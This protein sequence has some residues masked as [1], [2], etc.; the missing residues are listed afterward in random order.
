MSDTALAPYRQALEQTYLP[1]A[2]VPARPLSLWDTYRA[3][4]V[5]PADPM[6]R[7]QSAVT[8]MRHSLE[9]AALG[10]LLGAIHGKM[11]L[12]I[13]GKYPIDGIL[14]AVLLAMSV[15]E[16]HKPDGFSSD[17]RALS[18]CCTSV[19]FFRKTS[20]WVSKP[21]DSDPGPNMSRHKN[22]DPIL[23]AAEEFDL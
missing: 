3:A 10:A 5:P 16:A 6:A 22:K 17:L 9:S 2:P 1:A 18:Q 8:G 11:G 21:A 12:D 13:A 15:K 20:E 23:S 19:A 4:L 7:V 14:A